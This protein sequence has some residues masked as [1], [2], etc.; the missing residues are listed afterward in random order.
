[1]NSGAVYKYLT[2]PV[3]PTHLGQVLREAMGPVRRAAASGRT[4][5]RRRCAALQQLIVADR[6][7]T[8]AAMA[9]GLSQHLR[10]SLTAMSG[11]LEG[12]GATGESLRIAD[13]ADASDLAR[14]AV[15]EASSAA[16]G[17]AGRF[18]VE[19]PAGAVKVKV[20]AGAAVRMLRNLL[21]HLAR[22]APAGGRVRVT[23]EGPVPYWNAG[24]A[25][26]LVRGDGPG[27]AAWGDE[28]VALFFA[29]FA[30]PGLGAAASPAAGLGLLESFRVAQAHGGD[31]V[32]HGAAPIGPGF[33]VRLPLDPAAVR[34]PPLDVAGAVAKPFA[35]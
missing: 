4:C 1:M 22:R 16:G 13:E 2:K 27:W 31:L 8:V 9:S 32:T 5:S 33:E 7:K 28:E 11:Y 6:A 14:R 30:A 19:A 35:A 3:D 29:P 20:D 10:G 17:D 18:V 23:V 21:D 25:R 34:R 26:I 15:A 12:L 24:A